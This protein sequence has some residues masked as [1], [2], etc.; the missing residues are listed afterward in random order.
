MFSLPFS[1]RYVLHAS[2]FFA[3]LLI[4]N[5]LT[6]N[7]SSCHI[8]KE[9]SIAADAAIAAYWQS[10]PTADKTALEMWEVMKKAQDRMVKSIRAKNFEKYVFVANKHNGDASFDKVH[11][12]SL[13]FLLPS[14]HVF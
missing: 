1:I 11:F 6:S 12:H 7:C 13:L 10:T 8:Q 4:S 5:P 14:A 2:I 3:L 9:I